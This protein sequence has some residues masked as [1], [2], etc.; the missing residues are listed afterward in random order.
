MMLLQ[1]SVTKLQPQTLCVVC[2]RV[3][4]NAVCQVWNNI[5]WTQSHLVRCCKLKYSLINT[6]IVKS[7]CFILNVLLL[8]CFY[9]HRNILGTNYLFWPFIKPSSEWSPIPYEATIQYVMDKSRKFKKIIR[10]THDQLP[11]PVI[12]ITNC[13]N[14]LYNL[15]NGLEFPRNM[16]NH[17]INIISRR[18]YSQNKIN[19]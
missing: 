18:I 16:Q 13:Y 11:L 8:R 15:Q 5:Q 1:D 4:I 2:P 12:P 14:A 19:P 6:S 17:H 9:S 10:T 7:K 3:I